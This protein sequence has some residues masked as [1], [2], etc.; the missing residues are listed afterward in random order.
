MEILFQFAP[1]MLP[2][3]FFGT[4]NP[5]LARGVAIAAT[6]D[7][8]K[9]YGRSKKYRSAE[10]F[11]RIQSIAD[12]VARMNNPAIG[13]AIVGLLVEGSNA[14]PK[15][16]RCL[17]ASDISTRK[18]GTERIKYILASEQGERASDE[19]YEKNCKKDK[20]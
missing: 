20:P 18:T 12:D 4:R 13:D 16:V 14:I 8:R 6:R 3:K 10:Q 9:K 5:I 11:G 2:D 7:L 17:V 19:Y 15:D 1:T